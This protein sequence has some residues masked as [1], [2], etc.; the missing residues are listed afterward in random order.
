MAKKP[1]IGSFKVANKTR[2]QSR[3]ILS[4]FDEA[5]SPLSG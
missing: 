5:A 1:R 4:N 3:E 2:A